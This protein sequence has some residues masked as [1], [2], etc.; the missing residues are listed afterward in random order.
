N[1]VTGWIHAPESPATRVECEVA[2]R[3]DLVSL[4]LE[5]G[6]E[7][8]KPRE[9]LAELGSPARQVAGLNHEHRVRF[10]EGKG[11]LGIA[12]VD[13]LGELADGIARSGQ[14]TTSPDGST[15]V[16]GPRRSTTNA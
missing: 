7:G 8:D 16:S 3:D 4:R 9:R 1:T 5:G 6:L 13:R 14:G 12:W 15:A 11:S 2:C 10:V